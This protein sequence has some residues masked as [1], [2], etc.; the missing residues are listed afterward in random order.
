MG[1]HQT[2]KVALITGGVAGMGRAVAEALVQK[3]GWFV[4]LLDLNKET[5]AEAE[6]TLGENVQFIEA[7][8][9]N[10]DQQVAAFE[11]TVKKFGGID[12]VFAN[13]G[14]AGGA[15]FYGAPKSWPPGPPSFLVE[16]V[17]LRGAILTSYLAMQYMRRNPEPGGVIVMTAS[18]AAIYA[19]P[20]LP[21]YTAAKHGVLGLVRA[22]SERLGGENIRVN[23][24]L[25][26]AIR[27]TLHSKEIWEQFP[28][29]DFTPV[30]EVVAAVL[31]MVE[32][33]KANARQP[34]TSYL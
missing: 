29:Q 11:R 25:P 7:D 18:A 3:G 28:Q 8:V 27:T 26:G 2:M 32:D 33:G 16:E 6:R 31:G 19:A 9:T 15:D 17:C 10:Y 22:M 14:I 12:F 23:A 5:G 24:I 4:S 34:L 20:E 1:S 21:M 13:A 30:E